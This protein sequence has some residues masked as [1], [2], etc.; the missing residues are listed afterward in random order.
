[1]AGF[2]TETAVRLKCQ[3]EDTAAV[4][5]AL[6]LESIDDAHARILAELD[7]GVD[8]VTPEENLVAGETLLAGSCLMVSLASGEAVSV[9]PMMVGGH[10]I[11][12]GQRFASLMS[13]A[14]RLEREAWR[15]LAPY[16][17][18]RDGVIAGAGTDTVPVLGAE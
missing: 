7:P 16:I 10:R 5:S 4:S 12:A 11:E 9:R 2:T 13:L 1:M 14:S 6:V 3:V 15:L 8:T 18:A 17:A